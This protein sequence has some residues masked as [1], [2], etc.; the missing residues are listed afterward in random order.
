MAVLYFALA[1]T[2]IG[3]SSLA[4]PQRTVRC[5]LAAL[6]C[7][8]VVLRQK[9]HAR[10]LAPSLPLSHPVI[11]RLWAAQKKQVTERKQ[12]GRDC[13]GWERPWCLSASSETVWDLGRAFALSDINHWAPTA[14][15]SIPRI[16][17]EVE[18]KEN[19]EW[20]LMIPLSSFPQSSIITP[21]W[22]IWIR[23]KSTQIK[24]CGNFHCIFP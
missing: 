12:V 8:G 16:H 5:F 4:S 14:V 22:D 15:L 24:T 9:C 20:A 3:S 6:A 23:C 21:M 11:W 17:S 18:E 13:G 19:L 10:V 2:G 1:F 7:V